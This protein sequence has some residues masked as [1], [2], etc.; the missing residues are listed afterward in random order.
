MGCGNQIGRRAFALAAAVAG[1]VALA[2]PVTADAAARL[3]AHATALSFAN[4][5]LDQ[6]ACSSPSQCTAVAATGAQETFDPTKGGPVHR[7]QPIAASKVAGAVS[8]TCPSTGSCVEA[9]AS[10]AVAVFNPRSGAKAGAFTVTGA[11]YQTSVAC[12]SRH[13]CVAVSYQGAAAFNPL[14]P[15]QPKAVPFTGNG[16][17]A[18][19]TISCPSASLCV[20]DNGTDGS[21][22]TFSPGGLASPKLSTDSAA[23]QIGSVACPSTNECVALGTRPNGGANTA[24]L[25]FDPRHPGR[26]RPAPITSSTLE[27]VTCASTSL[28]AA[29]GNNSGVFVFD[30]KRPGKRHFVAAPVET[31]VVGIA[32]AGKS[33]VILTTKG[34]KA[35]IDPT[36]PPKSFHAAG[37]GKPDAV[38]KG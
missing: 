15:G 26:P 6:L 16:N 7:S 20:G 25:S 5:Y 13:S 35:V 37:L 33:L 36:A 1:C 17:G 10:G 28:C 12:P 21:V 2:V 38:A 4:G 11:G 24:I 32:F 19:A 31:D 27:F 30:P 14:H 29:A 22:Y 3:T 8:I 34:E 23:A 18:Q 9:G